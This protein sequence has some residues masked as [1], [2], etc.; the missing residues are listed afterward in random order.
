MKTLLLYVLLAALS[1]NA[2]SQASLS[3]DSESIRLTGNIHETTTYDEVSGSP[4]LFKEFT[5]S[6]V[7][8][9]SGNKP[10]EYLINYNAYKDQVEFIENDNTYAIVNTNKVNKIEID[11]QTF[12]Y[13]Q[14]HNYNDIKEGYFV[15]LVSD[16]ISLY[17]RE[18]IITI[19]TNK[20]AAYSDTDTKDNKFVKDKPLY[21][22]S[23]YGEPLRLIKN[24]KKLRQLFFN[25]PALDEFMKKEK[26][27][28]HSEEDLIKLVTFLSN[29]DKNS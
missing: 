2:Y 28:L 24:K 16:Y 1:F 20:S 19:S 26:I 29:F 23:V 13:S 7:Y 17:R 18:I 15:E 3:Y 25:H 12:V 9:K 27:K 4:Y 6:N 14:Y 8:F 10:V 22:I 21:Y 5:T 11:K